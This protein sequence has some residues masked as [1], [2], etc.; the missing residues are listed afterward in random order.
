MQ[1]YVVRTRRQ[2]L[3]L[4]S[5]DLVVFSDLIGRAAHAV[6]RV[7]GLQKQ[8]RLA[9]SSIFA[10]DWESG[11]GYHGS[12]EVDTALDPRVLLARACGELR[13]SRVSHGCNPLQVD[14]A[15]E[16]ELVLV[17]IELRHA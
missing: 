7:V 8:E 3:K 12:V 9:H 14:R 2:F 10:V 11:E 16:R 15:G 13:S 6:V 5:L 4:L 1:H 17:A